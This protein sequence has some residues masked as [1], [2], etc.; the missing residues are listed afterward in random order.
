MRLAKGP[1][2]PSIKLFCALNLASGIFEL[3]RGLLDLEYWVGALEGASPQYSWT[4]ESAIVLNSAIFTI[5]LIPIIAIWFFASTFARSFVTVFS[6]LGLAGLIFLIVDNPP[7]SLDVI[8]EDAYSLAIIAT[9][10]LLYLP[11]AHTWFAKKPEID[12]AT[13]I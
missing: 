5:M 3:V 6:L 10:V 7:A 1:R 9:F 2:P 8:L 13:F 12:P 11:S 4:T